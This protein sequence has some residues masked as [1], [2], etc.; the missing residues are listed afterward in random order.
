MANINDLFKQ[1][2]GQHGC[3]FQDTNAA[4]E[5]PS[6]MVIIAIQFLAENTLTGLVAENS[7]ENASWGLT[8]GQTGSG[9]GGVI[10]NSS[11]K[12]PAGLT[13]FGRWTS[14]TPTAD[15]DGG[16]ICY[17]GPK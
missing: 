17:F 6:G 7:S 1:S 11:N 16:I 9:S 14:V 15:S 2:F 3:A 10:I 8:A 12:F 5:P 13:I 4:V